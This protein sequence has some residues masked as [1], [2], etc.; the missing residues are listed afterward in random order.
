MEAHYMWEANGTSNGFLLG[1]DAATSPQIQSF[2]S[3]TL[4]AVRSIFDGYRTASPTVGPDGDVYL[5][6]M[7]MPT[8]SQ[9]MDAALQ[10]R[11]GHAQVAFSIRGLHGA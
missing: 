8:I 11:F 2:P 1:L 10:W 3:R 7:G 6:V 9:W 4:M 5:G